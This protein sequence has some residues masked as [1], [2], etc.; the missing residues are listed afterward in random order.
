MAHHQQ[1]VVLFK[2]CL[3]T[4]CGVYADTEEHQV[5]QILIFAFCWYSEMIQT[6]IVPIKSVT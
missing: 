1:M 4:P 3:L 6:E 5:S 2:Y